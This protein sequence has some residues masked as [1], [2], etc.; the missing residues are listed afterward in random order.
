VRVS[1]QLWIGIAVLIQKHI[2]R[3]SER[4]HFAIVDGDGLARGSVVDQHE[5]ATA[6]IA[7]A[8]QGDSY[9]KADR[10]RS[11]HGTAAI[12]KHSRTNF[13]RHPVLRGHHAEFAVHRVVHLVVAGDG[14][15]VCDRSGRGHLQQDKQCEPVSHGLFLL[16]LG[17]YSF[18]DSEEHDGQQ[19]ARRDCHHPGDEDTADDTQVNSLDAARESDAEYGS[20]QGMRR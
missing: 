1:G 6:N 9:G 3:C 10:D 7:G 5:P 14:L 12:F 8:R 18:E 13:G 19:G 4:R 17:Q 16:R 15:R 11:I 20:D 2:A